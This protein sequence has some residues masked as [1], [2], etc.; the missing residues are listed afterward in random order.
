VEATRLVACKGRRIE[1]LVDGPEDGLVLL[2][3]NGTPSAAV[4]MPQLTAPA[5][6]RGLRTVTYSRPGY[7]T[8]APDRGRSVADAVADTEAI[9]DALGARQCVAMGWSGGGPHALA[10]AALM[11]ERCL[12]AATLASVAPHNAEGLDWF[13][14]MGPENVEEFGAAEQGAEALA[15]LL[16]RWRSD[17]AEVTGEQVAAALGG[18][19]SGVDKVAL[20]DDFAEVMA[21]AFR[22]AV[23]TGIEGWL[24]D[25]LA[26]VRDWGFDLSAMRT[27]V[28]IWQGGQDRMVPL[29]HGR[30]LAEHVASAQPRFMDDDGHVS[31]VHHIDHILDDLLKLLTL[32]RPMVI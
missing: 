13:D 27:P 8:S 14:G 17:L 2:F 5:A 23:S 26:F 6:N 7:A 22:R 20:H 12:A 3:H 32:D 24:E 31:L 28:A 15:P 21:A 11:S 16:E 10:C 4:P 25:D 18:L 29:A 9:L 19:V 1:V 30:W